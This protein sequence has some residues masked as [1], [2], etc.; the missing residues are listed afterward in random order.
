MGYGGLLY[1]YL[2]NG[3]AGDLWY[4]LKGK[5]AIQGKL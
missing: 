4:L 5:W 1:E 3:L 2:V